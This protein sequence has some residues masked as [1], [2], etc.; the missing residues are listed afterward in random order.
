MLSRRQSISRGREQRCLCTDPPECEQRATGRPDLY[1]ILP[2]RRLKTQLARH[3]RK[4]TT[5]I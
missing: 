5:R 3:V 1:W 4:S 2:G